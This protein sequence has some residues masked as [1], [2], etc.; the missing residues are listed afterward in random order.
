MH[1]KIFLI[2]INH[3]NYRLFPSW[4]K[5]LI[6]NLFNKWIVSNSID[7]YLLLLEE[8]SKIE[9]ELQD[10][11]QEEYAYK[12]EEWGDSRSELA[13]INLTNKDKSQW[14]IFQLTFLFWCNKLN[15]MLMKE[16]LLNKKKMCK[17]IDDFFININ[18]FIPEEQ[19]LLPSQIGL[20]DVIISIFETS[21]FSDIAK[22]LFYQTIPETQA[23]SW[24]EVILGMI[25]GL[26]L[27]NTNL[28]RTSFLKLLGQTKSK[29]ISGLFA[30][31]SK[32]PNLEKDIRAIWKSLKIKPDLTLNLIDLLW[33]DKERDRYNPIL[34]IW[35][36]YCS[37]ANVV[38]TLV[39]IFKGDLTVVRRLAVTFEVDYH[40]LSIVLACA[41]KRIDLLQESYSE[42]STKLKIKNERAVEIVLEIAWGN[43]DKVQELENEEWFK[44][45]NISELVEI[46]RL[47]NNGIKMRQPHKRFEIPDQSNGWRIITDKL[48]EAFGINV[49]LEL[50]D[51]NLNN[52]DDMNDILCL[53]V[54]AVW[55]SPDDIFYITK[56]I[57]ELID[58]K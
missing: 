26:S 35:G 8:I 23:I 27:M 48:K 54:G 24:P 2:S 21:F 37:S 20:N 31:L 44:K 46:L 22:R 29:N 47:S 30:I 9:I 12:L 38:S 13:S 43:I 16:S 36:D 33:T 15:E 56:K 17:A 18:K 51:N 11:Q 40:M 50:S 28:V 53:I 57:E 6:L 39:S 1:Y 55:G 7:F 58:Q 5:L 4:S 10:I 49:N 52:L 34:N 41:W 25:V 42:I 45:I 19:K 3:Y 14:M 32:D